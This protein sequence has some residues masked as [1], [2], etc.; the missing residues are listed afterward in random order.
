MFRIVLIFLFLI[1]TA[2]W[3]WPKKP[4]TIPPVIQTSTT[5]TPTPS[6]TSVASPQNPLDRI[7]DRI[8]KKKFGDYITRVN[9]PVQ[10][11]RFSGYHTGLDLET[12]LE[13]Q[14]IAVPVR[15][16]CSG[17][18]LV[19]RTASGYGGVAVQSCTLAGQSVTVIYGHLNL[20]TI[21]KSVGESISRGDQIG[22]LGQGFSSQ[23]DGERKHLHLGIHRGTG[24]N[25][26]GYVSSQSALSS[27][28][29]PQI[30]FQQ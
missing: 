18:L 4:A 11:E 23:T 1:F 15:A 5:F 7:S 20:S 30:I 25:I 2:F 12:F 26:A 3:F 21:S 6:P 13:E 24:V 27:W 16:I 14:D 22:L 19:K 17:S 8:T 28:L 10:P 9:S 29:N